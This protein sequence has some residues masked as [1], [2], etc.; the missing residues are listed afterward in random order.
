MVRAE[1][2]R[3]RTPLQ[4]S[5]VGFDAS[6]GR[7]LSVSLSALRSCVNR[8]SSFRR[9]HAGPAPAESGAHAG[10]RR[11]IGISRGCVVAD[12]AHSRPATGNRESGSGCRRCWG[13]FGRRSTGRPWV[14]YTCELTSDA[15]VNTRETPRSKLAMRG[16]HPRLGTESNISSRWLWG[17][18]TL[19]CRA[20]S[21]WQGSE[22]RRYPTRKRGR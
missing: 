4:V 6:V 20:S 12:P 13:L 17:A 22:T 21:R 3:A 7:G 18:T 5:S 1:R 19:S 11:G 14:R 10:D 16:I 15:R 9:R 8:D 2:R